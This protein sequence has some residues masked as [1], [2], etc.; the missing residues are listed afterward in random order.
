MAIPTLTIDEIFSDKDKTTILN[1]RR[2]DESEVEELI[3]QWSNDALGYVKGFII[4]SYYQYI[5]TYTWSH[6]IKQYCKWKSLEQIYSTQEQDLIDRMEVKLYN[7]LLQVK[8][9]VMQQAE[10]NVIPNKVANFRVVNPS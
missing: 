5:D 8:D 9:N 3:I 1:E 2:I 4:E 10:L 7:Y 6:I